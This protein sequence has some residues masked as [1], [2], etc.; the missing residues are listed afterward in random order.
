MQ[1]FSGILHE[2]IENALE[3][4]KSNID[5]I[6]SRLNKNSSLPMTR[7]IDFAISLVQNEEG[8]NRLEYYLFNGSLIQ[9]NYCSLF[10][11]RRGD[12]PIVKKAYQQGLIDEIQAF[13]R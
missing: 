13:A 4:K 8:I 9:R 3:G 7:Y 6:M 5:F 10:F 1:K 11:N 12:W 2:L